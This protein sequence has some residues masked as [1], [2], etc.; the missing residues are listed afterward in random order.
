MRLEA[1]R[2]VALEGWWLL[3]VIFGSN[4]V[5]YGNGRRLW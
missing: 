5:G 2:L 1:M 3:E 4:S